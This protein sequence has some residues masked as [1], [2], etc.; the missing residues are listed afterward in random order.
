MQNQLNQQV[1]H[2]RPNGECTKPFYYGDS[3]NAVV[4]NALNDMH[5]RLTDI[6]MQIKLR[7]TQLARKRRKRNGRCTACLYTDNYYYLIMERHVIRFCLQIQRESFTCIGFITL[8]IRS[9]IKSLLQ[10]SL[11]KLRIGFVLMWKS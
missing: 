1:T 5:G 3:I 10:L 9:T 8:S 7:D 4:V 11:V 6:D 2:S